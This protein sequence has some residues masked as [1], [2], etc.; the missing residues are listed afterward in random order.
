MRIEDQPCQLVHNKSNIVF[1]IDELKL[2]NRGLNFALPSKKNPIND[3]IVDVESGIKSK[4]DF[5]NKQLVRC[6]TERTLTKN[7]S[8]YKLNSKDSKLYDTVNELQK[9]DCFY[10]KADKGN[11]IVIY[12]KEDYFDGMYDHIDESPYEKMLIKQPRKSK[13]SDN[14]HKSFKKSFK[15]TSKKKQ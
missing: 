11:A 14:N 6:L 15:R 5:P 8:N 2:L 1:S 10:L 7:L 12:N 3:L 13:L 9:K 4:C